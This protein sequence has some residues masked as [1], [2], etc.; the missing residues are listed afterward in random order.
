MG[1][2]IIQERKD[3][4]AEGDWNRQEAEGT[5]CKDNQAT[6]TH[7]C[8]RGE[9][10]VPILPRWLEVLLGILMGMRIGTQMCR[11]GTEGKGVPSVEDW[12]FC[13]DSPVMGKGT[14]SEVLYGCSKLMV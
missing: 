4:A 13:P 9:Q 11:E 14:T 2:I 5:G 12:F 7:G 10:V 1:R 6:M 8:G 3:K